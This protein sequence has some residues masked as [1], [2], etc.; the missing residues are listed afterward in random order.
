MAR[1]TIPDEE[2]FAEFTVVTST[3]AFPITFS[4]FAKADIT[5]LVDGVELD[6]ADFTFSGTILY[7]GGYDGGTVTLNTAVDDVT[8]RIERNVSLAR[9][10][11]FAPASSTPVGNVDLALNRLTAYAQ[12]LKRK[13]LDAPTFEVAGKYLAF[14][15]DG[16]PVASEGPGTDSGLRTDL[17]A[18]TGGALVSVIQSGTGAEAESVQTAVRRLGVYP[19]QFG[20][21]ADGTTDD[22]T[23]LGRALTA[24]A[25]A[26]VPLILRPGKDYRTTTGLTVP[27]GVEIIAYGATLSTAAAATKLLT[28][29]GSN[30]TIHGLK[31][32]G[33]GATFNADSCGFYA[34]GTVNG[35]AV[36]PTYLENVNLIDCEA[37][38][39][40]RDGIRLDYVDGAKIVR[41]R[42]TSLGYCGVEAISCKNVEIE[43]PYI[44]TLSGETDSGELNA[45][46][47]TFTRITSSSDTVRYPPSEDCSVVGG[48][49]KNIPTW[50]ALDTHG[51]QRITFRD[52]LVRECR[53]AAVLTHAT[54]VS[55]VDCLV[56]NVRAFNTAAATATNSNAT[57]KRDS[58]FWDIGLSSAV[59]AKRNRFINNYAFGYGPA[60]QN[61]GAFYFQ[62][63]NG[64]EYLNNTDENSYSVGL[65][66]NED[67]TDFR[68]RGHVTRNSR[69]PATGGYNT[70]PLGLFVTGNNQSGIIENCRTVRDDTSVDTYVLDGACY[71]GT[72][73][74]RAIKLRN[75]DFDGLTPGI[76]FQ[77]AD[78]GVTGDV[79]RDHTLTVVGFSDNE[80]A[81]VTATRNGPN[82]TLSFPLVTG[83]SDTTTFTMSGLPAEIRP[84]ANRHF[85]VK[86][87]D[88]GTVAFGLLIVSTDGTFTVGK[89]ANESDA[90]TASGNKRLYPIA[91]TYSLGSPE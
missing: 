49:I 87:M 48:T 75:N 3:S 14:D 88:T 67:V 84:T 17:A 29:D 66:I 85:P 55:S 46:G 76:T 36:A 8:V 89:S 59:P 74:G 34:T 52:V 38:G 64:C 16:V 45:Y 82:V 19:E 44:D 50:H 41:P 77:T 79:T 5:V 42:L 15:A 30:I 69:A 47:V 1:L 2:T 32:E 22:A 21:A 86:I 28:L 60:T 13:K 20:A 62:N 63:A 4:L 61:Y 80:S 23:A 72:G 81:T 68:L 71:I 27:A 70:V 11:N 25:A 6:Q 24:A 90:W 54:H 37:T 53:R 91:V 78:A 40:G 26:N 51:G 10:S 18:S 39:F 35:A 58:A 33:P 57:E 73:T 56:D 43:K 12:D 65:R 7:G 83:T 31:L 9:T